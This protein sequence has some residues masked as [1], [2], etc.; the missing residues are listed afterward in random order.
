MRIEVDFD[1]CESNGV[2]VQVAPEVFSI[3]EN[4][5]LHI[6]ESKAIAANVDRVRQAARMCPRQA[7]TLHED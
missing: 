6:D 4:E 1:L 3:D 5:F 2:C 7:I